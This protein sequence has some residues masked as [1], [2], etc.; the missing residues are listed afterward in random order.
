[1]SKTTATAETT[2][3]SGMGLFTV[4]FI[5]MFLTGNCDKCNPGNRDYLGDAINAVGADR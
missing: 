1:M 3:H 4:M 5:L 2:V